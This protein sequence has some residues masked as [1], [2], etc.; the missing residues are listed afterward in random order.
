MWG[1]GIAKEPPKLSEEINVT[2]YRE[3]NI[4]PLLLTPHDYFGDWIAEQKAGW[5]PHAFF[6]TPHSITELMVRVVLDT[7]DDMRG[8]KV[9]D[10]CLGSG[11]FLLHASNFS[12]R[13]YGIDIDE[14]LVK[15]S[16]VNGALFVPWMVRP[17]PDRL[18]MGAVPNNST[19]N[20]RSE[21]S[22]RVS[23]SS[24]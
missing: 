6:P 20:I 14:L 16:L 9:M 19:D 3:I 22:L 4:G 5:N 13:L 1:F 17:F 23:A 24:R 15:A 7:G 21:D 10:P 2:L 18:F 8:K 12:L 11:R